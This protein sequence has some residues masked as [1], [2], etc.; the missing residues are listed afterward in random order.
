MIKTKVVPVARLELARP[1]AADFESTASTDFAT[2]ASGGIIV[3]F[4]LYS[5]KIF[6]KMSEIN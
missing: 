2:Q 5:T 3:I 6:R 4:N 1:K